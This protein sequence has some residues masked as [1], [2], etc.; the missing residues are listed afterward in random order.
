MSSLYSCPGSRKWACK[1]TNAGRSQRSVPSITWPRSDRS[2]S[3]DAAFGPMR[4]IRPFSITTST[5]ASRPT[6]GSTARAPVITTKSGCFGTPPID[7]VIRSP[8]A[9]CR[10]AVST[11]SVP[12]HASDEATG[13]P[14]AASN[15]TAAVSPN[16]TAGGCRYARHPSADASKKECEEGDSNPHSRKATGT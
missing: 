9:S 8:I 7:S 12:T 5:T 6:E 10:A 4:V 11:A 15:S 3:G 1:S 16:S 2:C 13:P 14:G